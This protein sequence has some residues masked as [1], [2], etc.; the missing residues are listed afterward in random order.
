VVSPSIAEEKPE[1]EAVQVMR[2]MANRHET[3]T[4]MEVG[5]GMKGTIWR[6]IE[7]LP[8][9]VLLVPLGIKQLVKAT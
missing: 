5:K 3:R 2:R 9:L 1:G 6:R 7:E 8:L 4:K